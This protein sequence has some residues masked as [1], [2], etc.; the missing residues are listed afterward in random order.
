MWVSER[1]LRFSTPKD[2]LRA[3]QHASEETLDESEILLRTIVTKIANDGVEGEALVLSGAD[4]SDRKCFVDNFK[5]VKRPFENTTC[6]NLVVMIP[7]GIGA[8]IGGHAGDAGPVVRLLASICDNV[9]THP[10]VVNASDINEQRENAFYVEGSVLS[11]LLLGNIALQPVRKNRILVV[12]DNHPDECFTNGAINAV[13]AARATYGLDCASVTKLTHGVKLKVA[14]T[15]HGRAS[16][17]VSNLDVLVGMLKDRRDEYDAIAVSSVIDVPAGYHQKY[18]DAGGTMINP[19]GGVE[20]MLTHALS[21]LLN[22]PT[23]HAPMF[24]TR[25]IANSDPGVVDPRMAAEATSLTFLQCILKGLQR[26]PRILTGIPLGQNGMLDANAISCLVVPDGC[27]GTPVLGALAQ[28]ISVIAVKENVT[29]MDNDLTL[30]PWRPGQLHI[31][32]N[33][34]EAAGVIAALKA[35]ISPASVRRPLSSTS[36]MSMSTDFDVAPLDRSQ[37]VEHLRTPVHES[38]DV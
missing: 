4:P 23:A 16:G 19:W 5:L 36:V 20:A 34:W 29:L 13:N 31:V 32:D 30:L 2:W 37:R 18:F 26:S 7:T 15:A 12:I 3:L 11:R 22:V 8:E 38:K 14:Y 9:I 24:E 6:F 33:Y 35:G 27:I 17:E 25:E 10:N 28:G 1:D 21:T